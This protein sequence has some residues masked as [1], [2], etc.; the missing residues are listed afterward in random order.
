MGVEA[1]LSRNRFRLGNP[2]VKCED[3]GLEAARETACP[4]ECHVFHREW[5]DKYGT[6][7]T[8]RPGKA[9]DQGHSTKLLG[10][11]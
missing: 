1:D 6:P 5:R 2:N 3:C 9:R 11:R 7:D 8:V 4:N 10:P